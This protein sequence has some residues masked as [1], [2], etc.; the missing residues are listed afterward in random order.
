MQMVMTSDETQIQIFAD[1]LMSHAKRVTKDDRKNQEYHVVSAVIWKLT[2]TVPLSLLRSFSLASM[3]TSLSIFG[4]SDLLQ[5]LR[6]PAA[7]SFLVLYI[8]VFIFYFILFYFI[9]FLCGTKD[10]TNKNKTMTTGNTTNDT[11]LILLTIQY[12][13]RVQFLHYFYS[14]FFQLH[15]YVPSEL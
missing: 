9:F 7:F 12:F 13:L 5:I 10:T 4:W 1:W 15:T 2:K 3:F 14:F 11:L 6:K 8:I